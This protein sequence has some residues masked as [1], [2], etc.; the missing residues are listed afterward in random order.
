MY[1]IGDAEH[2]KTVREMQE[3]MKSP[4]GTKLWF[5]TKRKEFDELPED[6]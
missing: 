2:L 4:A 5:E 1:K 3:L 6:N